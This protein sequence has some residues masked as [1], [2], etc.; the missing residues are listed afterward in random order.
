MGIA[1]VIV[2]SWFSTI[3][4]GVMSDMHMQGGPEPIPHG[5]VVFLYSL[6]GILLALVGL[7]VLAMVF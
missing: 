1:L 3:E 2:S 6:V 4:G 5:V 7:W